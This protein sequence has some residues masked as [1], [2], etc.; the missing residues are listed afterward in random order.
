MVIRLVLLVTYCSVIPHKVHQWGDSYSPCQLTVLYMTNYPLLLLWYI[1]LFIFITKTQL[2]TLW[3]KIPKAGPTTKSKTL[4]PRLVLVKRDSGL[5]S[6]SKNNIHL[7]NRNI[8]FSQVAP[9]QETTT[10]RHT[11]RYKF[12]NGCEDRSTNFPKQTVNKYTSEAVG[13]FSHLKDSPCNGFYDQNGV[14]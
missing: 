4:L 5:Y 1:A 7:R 14:V 6:Y 12:M 13:K 8:S 10:L 11:P 2:V 9:P 3:V